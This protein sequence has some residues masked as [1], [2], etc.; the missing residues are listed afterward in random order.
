VCL[1]GKAKSMEVS[2]ASVPDSESRNTARPLKRRGG[3][4][5]P[6]IGYETLDHFEGQA[7]PRKV[8]GAGNSSA[9]FTDSSTLKGPTGSAVSPS[10]H[11]P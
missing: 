6:N 3:S 7:N 8:R 10:S 4:R 1:E 5:E 2:G 9:G 11:H